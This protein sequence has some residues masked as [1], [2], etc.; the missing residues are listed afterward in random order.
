MVLNDTSDLAEMRGDE[1]PLMT[2][3]TGMFLA[4]SDSMVLFKPSSEMEPMTT[5]CAPAATQ[6]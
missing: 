3:I 1:M 5:I 6:S 4:C 2:S